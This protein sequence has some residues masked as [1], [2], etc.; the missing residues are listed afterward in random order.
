MLC[1]G[2]QSSYYITPAEYMEMCQEKLT[3]G[4]DLANSLY[5]KVNSLTEKEFFGLFTEE[6]KSTKDENEK[7][8]PE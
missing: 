2:K 6:K 1:I 7:D 8:F 5:L 4:E 3:N